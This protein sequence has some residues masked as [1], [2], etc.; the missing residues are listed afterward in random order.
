MTALTRLRDALTLSFLALSAILL[1]GYHY[2]F[3]DQAIWLPAIKNSLDPSLYPHDSIFFLAQTRFSLFPQMMA[4][5]IKL[6]SLPTDV[7]VFLWHLF[8]IFL[9]LLGCLKL[10]RHCFP[11]PCAQWAAV[12]TICVARLAPVAGPHLNLMDRYLHP[13]DLATGLLLLALVAVFKRSFTALLWIALAAVIHPTMA[14]FGAFHLAIQAWSQPRKTWSLVIS[15]S[16]ALLLLAFVYHFRPVANPAWHEILLTRPYLFPPKWPWYAWICTAAVLATVHWFV[17]IAR[18]RELPVVEHISR[19]IVISGII[20]IAGA[21]LIT[22]VPAFER[23]IPT[24][25]MR[26]LHLVYFLLVFLGG[27]LLGQTVLQSHPLR[28]FVFLFSIS[29]VFLVGNKIVYSSSPYIE[30]PGRLPRNAW[31]AAF[32]WIRQNTPNDAYFALDPHYMTRPGEDHHGF[33]AFAER[34]VLADWVKDRSVSALEPQLADRWLEEES[35]TNYWE[36]FTVNDLLQL[37]KRFGV[38]WI[39]LERG[40][41]P[42]LQPIGNLSCPYSNSAVLV[43]KLP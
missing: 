8:S 13:R 37:K 11:D 18:R 28:W 34:S 19:R 5:F 26:T 36:R 7:S 9:V 38:D 22:T 33:R 25:P 10:A 14:V 16:A 27:G 41:N 29:A 6:T 20:G 30:V 42:G 32:D 23:L 2:G 43:C 24:E 40:L 35:G 31:V 4:F 39:V 17:G 12:A 1:Q 21:V 15:A 3:E